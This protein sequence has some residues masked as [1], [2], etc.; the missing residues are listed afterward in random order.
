MVF[1]NAPSNPVINT[2]S[3]LGKKNCITELG[4]VAVDAERVKKGK[5]C[6]WC[7]ELKD[8]YCFF[9]CFYLMCCSLLLSFPVV[10]IEYTTQ[11]QFNLSGYNPL[12]LDIS[13]PFNDKADGTAYIPRVGW[14]PDGSVYAQVRL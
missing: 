10:F 2:L 6:V 5:V 13:T 9:K 11:D 14:L 4:V 7:D 3:L 1:A 8:N 12:W